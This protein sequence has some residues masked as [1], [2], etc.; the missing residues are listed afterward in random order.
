MNFK[1][2]IMKTFNV[3]PQEMLKLR[4]AINYIFQFRGIELKVVYDLNKLRK[5]LNGWIADWETVASL[6][7]G[8]YMKETPTKPF[9]PFYNYQNFKMELQKTCK[10]TE[11]LGYKGVDWTEIS[12]I[13]E[14]YEIKVNTDSTSRQSSCIPAEFQE[15]FQSEI[16]SAEIQFTKTFEFEVIKVS[17][18]F[19]NA[20]CSLPAELALSVLVLFEEEKAPSII[21]SDKKIIIPG[22]H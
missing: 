15:A 13:M 4:E 8:K 5:K 6:I 12:G 21:M 20:L 19:M 9:I 17:D 22:M 10:S 14:K 16:N 18:R 11:D 2:E 7:Y 1:G 3:G